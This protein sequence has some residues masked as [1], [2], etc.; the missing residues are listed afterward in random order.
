MHSK[1]SV[2]TKIVDI[3]ASATATI[4]FC[5]KYKERP[6]VLSFMSLKEYTTIRGQVISNSE[7][8]LKYYNVIHENIKDCRDDM[9]DLIW[10]IPI[11]YHIDHGILL[12]ELVLMC[13]ITVQM[14]REILHETTAK[15]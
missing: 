15:E 7:L 9:S 3:T 2:N 8:I 14:G 10:K 12:F 5:D 1:M 11:E 6:E 4:K 13:Y